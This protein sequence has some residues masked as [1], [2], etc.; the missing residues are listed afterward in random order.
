MRLKDPPLRL[1]AGDPGE[2]P[3]A[4]DSTDG[5]DGSPA[6][7]NEVALAPEA[8]ILEAPLSPALRLGAGVALLAAV[9]LRFWTPSALW[10]DE[11]LTVDIARAPVH[12]I[13]GL[14]RHDG[15]PPLF[16]VL[17]HYWMDVF[18]Q[19]DLATRS[20]SGVIGLVNLPVAW[21]TGYRFGCHH[22]SLADAPEAEKVSRLRRGRAVA[23]A[24]TMLVASSPFVIYYDTEARMYGLVILLGT[25]L[26]LAFTWLLERPGPLPA[27]SI[28][29]IASA[30]LYSHYWAFYALGVLGV[31][32]LWAAVK[33]PHRRAWRYATAGLVL[34][35]LSFAPWFPTFWF[36]LHHTGTPW[37][38]PAGLTVVV[39]A[40]TQFAGGNT[41]P[42]R[43]LAT[44]FFLFGILAVAGMSF[45]RWRVL[46]DLR[47]RP[48]VRT[49]AFGALAV[50]II[51]VL[52]DKFSGNTFADRYTAVVAFATLLVMA[53]GLTSFSDV[54]TR[55]LLLAL[56]VVCGLFAAIPNAFISRTQAGQVGAAIAARAKPNAVVAYCP[57][58]LGPAVS[59][60]L[61]DRFKEIAFPRFNAPEIVN[62]VDYLKVARAASPAKFV[63]KVKAMAGKT[64]TVYYVWTP[65]YV[66]FGSKCS[67]IAD[68]L[69][70]WPGH[71]QK[72]LVHE[73]GPATPFEVY[74]GETLDVFSPR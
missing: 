11:A 49:V 13:P 55:R 21:I 7:A 31:I 53:Y 5:P 2:V 35:A 70:R 28:A 59:R 17:L 48:G 68:A 46:L 45:D 60:V 50:L 38:A 61:D 63:A 24:V 62:W 29:A 22:W 51:G 57:D 23:W 12:L 4:G 41:D 69:H 37:A 16:Y 66:G 47:T 72:V 73:H 20:L 64:G 19:S 40:V 33:G 43:A 32:S 14:L 15:A 10:L 27:L 54:R 3:G 30:L 39:F 18:G 58:Q 26:V 42:G 65:G 44:I 25:L 9:V 71:T 1:G 67:A 34:A 74:E 36:Q 52:A 6:T 56:A 8:I